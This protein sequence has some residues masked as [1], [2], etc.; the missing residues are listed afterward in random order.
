[1]S[2]PVLAMRSVSFVTGG[3]R[4]LDAVDLEIAPGEQL[5]VVAASG[6]GKSCL[7]SLALGMI[8]PT[9]G[10]VA[11]FGSDLAAEPRDRLGQLRRRCG[12]LFQQGALISGL[13]VEDNLWL[14]LDAPAS[15]RQRLRRRLIR[16]AMD[17]DIGHI[18]PRPAQTLSSG[19]RQRVALARALLADPELVLLDEPLAGT[20]SCADTMEAAIRRQVI[21]R[22][23]AMLLL[24]QD[25]ALARR[26][27]P[28]VLVLEQGRLLPLLSG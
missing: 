16:I 26:L 20:A 18:L 27:C 7:A 22:N 23:R 9:A 2:A 3:A 17:F 21:G 14:V 10:G 12:A 28:R 6:L 5:A 24:T 8:A 1:M 25:T 19:E 13:T 11:L 15:A 4:L